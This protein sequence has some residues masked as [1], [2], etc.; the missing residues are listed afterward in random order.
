MIRA[1][2]SCHSAGYVR[3]SCVTMKSFLYMYATSSPLTQPVYQLYKPVYTC[4]LG[5][6]NRNNVI[7]SYEFCN[8]YSDQL[9]FAHFLWHNDIINTGDYRIQ[10]LILIKPLLILCAIYRF[11]PGIII[12]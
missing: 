4:A 8:H 10:A 2:S 3:G 11:H 5:Q 7:L 1:V 6:A 12:I 9:I